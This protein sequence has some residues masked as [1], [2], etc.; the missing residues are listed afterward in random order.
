[1]NLRTALEIY[2][3]EGPHDGMDRT[4]SARMVAT[5]VV[6]LYLTPEEILTLTQE[7]RGASVG[8]GPFLQRLGLVRER[9]EAM[10][11]T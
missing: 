8:K 1:M 10:G 3:Q 7:W 2:E 4:Q 11:Y 6:H 5:R 9:L